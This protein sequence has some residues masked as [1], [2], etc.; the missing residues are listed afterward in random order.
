MEKWSSIPWLFL[1]LP[2]K[3]DYEAYKAYQDGLF[4]YI[5]SRAGKR[6]VVDSSKTARYAAGR[7]L[8][9]SKIADQDVY[10]LHLVRNGLATMESLLL[11]GSNWAIEGYTRNLKWAGLR[12]AFGWARANVSAYVVARLLGPNRY[13]LLRYEDFIVDPETSLQK[14]GRFVG[15]DPEELIQRLKQ[16]VY[17]QVGHEVGGN[18]IRL[19]GKIRVRKELKTHYGDHLKWHHKFIFFFVGGWLN[20]HFGYGL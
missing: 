5:T 10:I 8:A 20:H 19:E 15:F 14:I 7:F 9:L 4:S 12:A 1:G 17:F 13:M 2:R 16:N 11:K 3:E 18:R 6:I